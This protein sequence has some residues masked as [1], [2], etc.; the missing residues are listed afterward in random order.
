MPEPNWEEFEKESYFEWVRQN[1]PDEFIL[2]TEEE[3]DC[4][5]EQ[6]ILGY[7]A[8]RDEV[9]EDELMEYVISFIRFAE[10]VQVDYDLVQ[11]VLKGMLF[12]RGI[13]GE[14]DPEPDFAFALTR[15]GEEV[16]EQLERDRRDG[17]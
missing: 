16:G 8:E 14:R 6:A 2:Y 13:N 5:A 17:E 1:R 10:G 9:D 3:Y 4:L 7:L 15:L 12:P 11:L